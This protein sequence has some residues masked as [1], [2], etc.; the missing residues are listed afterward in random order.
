MQFFM[1]PFFGLKLQFGHVELVYVTVLMFG[2]S[3]WARRVRLR[4]HFGV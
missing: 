2:A 4:D 1:F 3:L